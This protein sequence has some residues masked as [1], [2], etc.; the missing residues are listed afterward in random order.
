MRGAGKLDRSTA[1]RPAK[2]A[3]LTLD[4]FLAILA[5]YTVGGLLIL[6]HTGPWTLLDTLITSGANSRGFAVSLTTYVTGWSSLPLWA[7]LD[8]TAAGG[9]AAYDIYTLRRLQ[10]HNGQ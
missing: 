1:K 7:P 2:A 6:V 8:L 3:V 5:L 10:M 4:V 9:Q